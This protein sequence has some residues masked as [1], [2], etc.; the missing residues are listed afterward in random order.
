MRVSERGIFM[1][2]VIFFSVVV[3]SVQFVLAL[4]S[5][6][7]SEM[8][9][10]RTYIGGAEESDLKLVPNLNVVVTK[11]PNAPTSSEGF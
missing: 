1:L 7:I 10:Q 2:K 4:D 9:K 11:D 3:L 5:F 6:E 8:A